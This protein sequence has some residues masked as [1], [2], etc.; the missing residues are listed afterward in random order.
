MVSL[1]QQLFLQQRRSLCT[2][3]WRVKQVNNSNFPQCLH[4]INT[5]ITHSDFVA[6]SMEKTGFPAPPSWHRVL[7]FDTVETAYLKAR[8][9]AHRFQLLQFSVCPFSISDSKS[10]IAHPYNFLLFPR[11]ELSMGMPS[12][13]F[14]CQPSALASM[15]SQG[16]DFNACINDGISYLSRVQESVAK[17][18]L[19]TASPSFCVMK[20]SSISTFADTVF[21]ERIKSRIKHWRKTCKISC[22]SENKDEEL[23]NSLR[24]I[25]LGSEQFRSRPCLTVDVCSER[26]V[27]L[28][29]EML[30][31]ISDDLLPL[32]IPAKSGSTQAVR[33]VLANS[34]EDK[35]FLERE[36]QN[37][38]EEET[39]KI[40]GFREV[41]DLISASQK[42]VISY[43]SL[44]DCT[45]IHSKFIAP[46]PTEVDEFVSSMCTVFPKVLD[47]NYLIRVIGTKRKVANI[48]NA[49]SYLNN[50]F[51]APVDVKIPDQ[52]TLNEGKS[53][54]INALRLC[55]LF[56]KLCSILKIS[57]YV[58]ESGS[59]HLAAELEDVSNVFHP[60]PAADIQELP[61]NEDISIWAK[62][63]RKV[64]IENV[65]FLWGF[66][67]GTT[68]GMLKSLLRASNDIFLGEFDV[69]LVDK[70]C[71][72]VVFWQPSL[73]R[74]FLDVMNGKEVSGALK[75]LVS[76]GIRVASYQTYKTVCRLGLWGMDLAESL[77]RAVE[78][79]HCDAKIDSGRKSS[80][81]HW[82]NDDI[83][84][85]DDL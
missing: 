61:F 63:A 62:N 32:I 81:I 69:K 35:D 12:Y 53:H 44:N 3:R 29:M 48:P 15:A 83:I 74:E 47:V 77:E 60:C 67:F 49:I 71:A 28:I 64:C 73:S 33:V 85:F 26:Q 14:S 70:S 25:V 17:I 6:L 36:L 10:L 27:Q 23:M 65:V 37:V 30:V 9:S 18:R 4:E 68:A 75:E 52:G 42:P 66:K 59:K 22:T 50:H 76:D 1:L 2:K 24:N 79:S 31:E 46:L 55:Y 51:F 40:R 45:L 41:I 58:N 19:G 43:N 56:I 5:H 78:S 54:G 34:K 11:D 16:F 39:K 21:V 38:E 20:S 13:S 82:Y 72:I 7:P 57:P 80:E 8:L 84:N